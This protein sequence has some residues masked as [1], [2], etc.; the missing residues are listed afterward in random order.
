LPYQ[1]SPAPPSTAAPG[2]PLVL[3]RLW[4]HRSLPKRGFVAFIAATA[5]LLAIPLLSVLGSPM[6]WALLPFMLATLAGL[7][8][9]LTRSYQTGTVSETLTLTP[10][11]LTLTRTAPGH[12]AQTWQSNPHWVTL[13]LHPTGGPVPE[14]LTLQGNA[15]EVELGAFLTPQ[16]RTAL[17]ADLQAA[18]NRATRP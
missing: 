7:W 15:R 9:A 5:A 6:L 4:P 2:Q 11:S 13:R 3:L 16:E 12:P 14:Y 17:H 10:E 8:W 1:W 18:L